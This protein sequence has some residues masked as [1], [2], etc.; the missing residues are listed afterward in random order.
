[1]ISFVILFNV[2]IRHWLTEYAT[3]MIYKQTI[4]PFVEYA[5]LMFVACN[6]EENN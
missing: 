3:K 2:K 5:G 4:L 6:I 1:M